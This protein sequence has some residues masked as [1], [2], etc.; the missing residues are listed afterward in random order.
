MML[1]DELLHKIASLLVRDHTITAKRL[2]DQARDNRAIAD[3]WRLVLDATVPNMLN[4]DEQGKTVRSELQPPSD[5][6]RTPLSGD[7]D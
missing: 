3:T 1:N 2:H 5:P 6:F 7:Y 4:S